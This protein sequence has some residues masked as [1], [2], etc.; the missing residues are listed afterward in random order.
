MIPIDT[1]V[2]VYDEHTQKKWLDVVDGHKL[3]GYVVLRGGRIVPPHWCAAV[4]F[5]DAPIAR[6]ST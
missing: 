4:R 1:P 6:R 2:V 3:S 5:T